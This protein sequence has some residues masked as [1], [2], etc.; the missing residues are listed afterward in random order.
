[1]AIKKSAPLARFLGSCHKSLISAN[2]VDY[3]PFLN[4]LMSEWSRACY[5]GDVGAI[6]SLLATKGRMMLQLRESI[7]YFNGVLHVVAGVQRLAVP[8]MRDVLPEQKPDSIADVLQVIP[9]CLTHA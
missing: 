3:D 5:L 1:M 6:R 2:G 8:H 4:P 9:G 7:M